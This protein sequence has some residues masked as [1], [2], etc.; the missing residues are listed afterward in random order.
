M[1]NIT[2]RLQNVLVLE[3]AVVRGAGGSPFFSCF[4]SRLFFAPRDKP[5][6]LLKKKEGILWVLRPCCCRIL[7]E[8]ESKASLLSCMVINSD[9]S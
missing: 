6:C 3:R 8:G 1:Y 4:Q 2:I 5:L 9:F 7:V